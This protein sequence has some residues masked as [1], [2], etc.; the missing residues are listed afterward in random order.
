MGREADCFVYAA[1]GKQWSIYCIGGRIL[2]FT[3]GRLHYGEI[4]VNFGGENTGE[5]FITLELPH[6]GRNFDFDTGSG[7]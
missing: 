1:E 7:T 6:G 3:L 5:I 4:L 2:V